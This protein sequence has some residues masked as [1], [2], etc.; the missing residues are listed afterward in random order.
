MGM[1]SGNP[2]SRERRVWDRDL[3]IGT[4]LGGG[5]DQDSG[6]D[7]DRQPR[8]GG[9]D[10]ERRPGLL[11]GER[12]GFPKAEGRQ[13]PIAP[14][15]PASPAHFSRP[16][17]ADPLWL[18]ATPPPSPGPAAEPRKAAGRHQGDAEVRWAA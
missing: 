6:L 4:G 9:Q 18:P 16:G 15:L 8:A 10:L 1:G 2:D 17:L 7:E 13:S 12:C 11:T 3:K 5:G 14:A